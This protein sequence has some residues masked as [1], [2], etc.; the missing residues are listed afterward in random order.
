ME[1]IPLI[2]VKTS[3]L[4]LRKSEKRQKKPNLKAVENHYK[5]IYLLLRNL[6]YE[7]EN[8]SY[9]LVIA[10]KIQISWL[11]KNSSNFFSTNIKFTKLNPCICYNR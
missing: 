9:Y 1:Y 3:C 6:S 11:F 4:G 8:R 7:F 2:E 10:I 5:K